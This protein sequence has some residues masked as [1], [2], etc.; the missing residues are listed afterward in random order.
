MLSYLKTLRKDTRIT[1][2][3]TR[4]NMSSI[5]KHVTGCIICLQVPIYASGGTVGQ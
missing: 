2:R 3:R 4:Q 1:S 5:S